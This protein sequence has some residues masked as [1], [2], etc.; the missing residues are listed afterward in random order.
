MVHQALGGG[1]LRAVIL[2]YLIWTNIRTANMLSFHDRFTCNL[3]NR[4]TSQIA[5]IAAEIGRKLARVILS[6]AVQRGTS[7]IPKTVHDDRLD[8]NLSLCVLTEEQ[9]KMI[10]SLGD[11]VGHIWYLDPRAHIC[12]D[13]FN[14]EQDEPMKRE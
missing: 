2:T 5:Q 3:I 4:P 12:F 11:R 7:V 13:V 8:E 10:D 9:F 6:W 1:S 14:E